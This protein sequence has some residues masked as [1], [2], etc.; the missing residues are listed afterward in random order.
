MRLVGTNATTMMNETENMMELRMAQTV[1]ELDTFYLTCAKHVGVM[2]AAVENTKNA[3]KADINRHQVGLLSG[4]SDS[5]G[6]K[7]KFFNDTISCLTSEVGVA[8]QEGCS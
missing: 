4:V 6:T 5:V 2:N 1:S 7:R 3:H 8:I